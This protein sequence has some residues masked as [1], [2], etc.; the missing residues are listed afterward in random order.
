MANGRVVAD[1]GV[2][3]LDEVD[4]N[5]FAAFVKEAVA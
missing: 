2:E 1:G 5:G 4:K 3:L